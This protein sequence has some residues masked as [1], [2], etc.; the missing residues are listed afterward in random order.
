MVMQIVKEKY[1]DILVYSYCDKFLAHLLKC[2]LSLA[3]GDT[4]VLRC[5]MPLSISF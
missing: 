5:G 3:P 2:I 1:C 4:Y